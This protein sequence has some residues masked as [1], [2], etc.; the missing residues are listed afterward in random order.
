MCEKTWPDSYISKLK[1]KS[2]ERPTDPA[3]VSKG[4]PNL[5]RP[6]TLVSKPTNLKEKMID[7]ESRNSISKIKK[8]DSNTINFKEK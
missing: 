4:I 6:Q 2:E 5:F 8:T 3:S 1:R 7:S